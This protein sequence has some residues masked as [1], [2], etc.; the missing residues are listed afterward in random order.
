MAMMATAIKLAVRALVE[1][2]VR[3][4]SERLAL[5][6]AVAELGIRDVRAI[7]LAHRLVLETLKRLNLLDEVA[8]AALAGEGSL[9][10]L[11][12]RARAFLRL[13][14][15]R[16]VVEGASRREL[17]SFVLSAREALGKGTLRP[18]ER[19]LGRC[20]TLSLDDVLASR[21]GDE[22]LALELC[23]PTWLLRLLCRDLGRQVAIGLLKASLVQAPSYVRV[24]T[25][26]GEEGEILAS[27][28][29]EGIV[30][31]P[32]EGL[33]HVYK[34]VE[35][36]K[37]I[38]LTDAYKEGLV[39]PQDKASCLAVEVANP[40]PGQVVLDVC[41]APGAKTT[42]MAQL[43][44]N[45]GLII[46]I[47]FSRRRL[48]AWRKLVARMGVKV[49]FPILADARFQLPTR[50]RADVV[51]L[52]L[53]CTST[54]AFAKTP[55]AKWRLGPRSPKN[56]AKVQ[57]RILRA[58]AE[59]VKPGG[60]L[61]YTTCSLLVEENERV[62]EGFLRANPDFELER[63][64]PFLGLPGLRGLS[65]AQRLYPHIH[66]CDGYF[67]AKLRRES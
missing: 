43:M 26:R 22:R 15:Y 64:E 46:S 8:K 33:R 5:S 29:Q 35:A 67:I 28:E 1:V 56:M 19:A 27:L 4:K 31:E 47:D 66:E 65:K 11:G 23:V 3:R 2:G 41:A 55:S 12:A 37:P 10:D 52:D 30:L 42:Y 34:V 54:G 49:A 48:G 53:P 45:R 50:L 24:N 51:L 6:E 18:I 38:I 14:A 7:G 39:Y 9:E 25:L 40:R 16:A 60:V 58:S 32:V 13:F 61:I 59:H 21:S 57:A 62:L 63:P 44:G 36:G 20:T 17:A